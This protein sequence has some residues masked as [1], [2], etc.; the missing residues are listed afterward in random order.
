VFQR[1]G[2]LEVSWQEAGIS[3][4][5]DWRGKKIGTWGYGHELELIAAMRQAGINP[6]DPQQVTIVQQPPD[7]ALLLTRQIDAAQAMIYNEYAQ[8]LEAVNP[9]TGKLYQ[10][11]E[12]HVINFNDVG[13]AMLQDGIFA[14]QDWLAK[15]V[16]QETAIKFLRASFKGWI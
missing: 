10:P 11:A 13:T 9:D 16:N 2:T 14:R 7:M 6:Q 3:S 8:V 5:A 15:P 1:S 12:L 4:P